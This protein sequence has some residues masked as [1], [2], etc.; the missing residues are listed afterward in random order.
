FDVVFS[1]YDVWRSY[2]RSV[3]AGAAGHTYGCEPIRQVYRAGD[4]IHGADDVASMMTWEEGLS[5]PG[6]SQLKLL[7]DQL[8]SRSYFTR[9]P[10][11]ERVRPYRQEP[12][13]PDGMNVGL[14]FA[15][16][17]NT[18]PIARISAARCRD[19]HYVMAYMPVRQILYLDVTGLASDRLRLSVFDPE[20]GELQDQREFDTPRRDTRQRTYATH[21]DDGMLLYIPKRDLDTFFIIDAI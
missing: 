21:V 1:A 2:Y 11:Q 18:D 17:Q 14:D 5:L 20:T 19:G 6:A 8:L 13:W 15:G 4:R 10:A 7:K 3:L 12:A 9:V 16:Q